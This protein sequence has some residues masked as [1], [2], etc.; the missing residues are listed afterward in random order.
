MVLSRSPLV[1]LLLYA[2]VVH[3]SPSNCVR[4]N[5]AIVFVGAPSTR[6]WG[7]TITRCRPRSS[8][9]VNVCA[10]SLPHAQQPPLDPALPVEVVGNLMTS[11][12]VTLAS[13]LKS[14]RS[15]NNDCL[16]T[17]WMDCGCCL[18]SQTRCPVSWASALPLTSE[19][20]LGI[21][22]NTGAQT[23]LAKWHELATALRGWVDPSASPTASRLNRRGL[24]Q[25]TSADDVIVMS[26]ARRRLLQMLCQ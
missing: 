14:Q 10:L 13:K 15:L 24:L 26:H 4:A 25:L 2:V 12:R 1:Q 9:C 7:L 19:T 16:S 5:L 17:L 8:N 6:N 18:L 23:I 11:I 3:K 21:A 22:P 20:E